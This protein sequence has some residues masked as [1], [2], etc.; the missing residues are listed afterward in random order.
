MQVARQLAGDRGGAADRGVAGWPARGCRVLGIVPPDEALDSADRRRGDPHVDQCRAT[1]ASWSSRPA[2][3]GLG[4]GGLQAAPDRLR[5]RDALAGARARP[6]SRRSAR[7]VNDIF[8]MTE[9]IPVTGHHLLATATCTTTSTPAT[10]SSSTSPPARRPRPGALATRGD[11]ARSSRTGSACRSS[12]T[13]PATSSGCCR[14]SRC[15]CEIAG[16]PGTSQI[17]GKADQLLRRRPAPSSPRGSSSRR[18]RRCRPS[19][20]RPASAP[21]CGRSVRLTLPDDAVAGLGV[22]RRAPATSPNAAWTSTS[23]SS[24]TTRR[25][26][27]RRLRS[28]LREITFAYRTATRSEPDMRPVNR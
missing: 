2:R 24:Q 12:G 13:T 17:V 6:R 18:S 27:L 26:A 3:R 25:P 22:R 10:S 9:V 23:G 28:D 8:G 19:R 20:G 16:L 5:R 14:T 4:P 15:S 11:H 1:S 7:R 21:P